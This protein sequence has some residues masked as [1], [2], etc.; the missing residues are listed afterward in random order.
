M[1]ECM[2]FQSTRSSRRGML[3][4]IIINVLIFNAIL[5]G[6]FILLEIIS[7][8]SVVIGLVILN[9]LLFVR[10]ILVSFKYIRLNREDSFHIDYKTNN[11]RFVS[12]NLEIDRSFADIKQITLFK[13]NIGN[14]SNIVFKKC[15]HYI[16]SFESDSV[17][18]GPSLVNKDLYFPEKIEVEKS[19]QFRII[20]FSSSYVNIGASYANKLIKD[21][22]VARQID[23]FFPQ[24]PQE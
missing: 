18:I 6:G 11:M 1:S 8:P 15:Y 7:I 21:D 10:P 22:K 24:L 5:L 3:R 23:A 13:Y 14:E 17:I 12:R 9:I 4:P 19:R 20:D 2:I 16:I